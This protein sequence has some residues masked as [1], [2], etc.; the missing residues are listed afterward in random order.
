MDFI[1]RKPLIYL[2]YG[3]TNAGKNV[4]ANIIKEYY[5]NKNKKVI[6]TNFTK[7]LKIYA[8]EYLNWDGKDET[9]PRS[10]LQQ[11]GTEIIRE[12][13]DP[14]FH[15]NRTCQDI[16]IYSYL[17]DVIIIND[18]RIPEEINIIKKKYKNI[19]SIKILRPD[20]NNNLTEEQNNHYTEIALD[21]YNKW[22]YTIEN[23]TLDELKKDTIKI[24]K[25]INKDE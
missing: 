7:Y 8:Q 5:Q 4:L 12:K 1:Y 13:I 18:V 23:K 9:K 10:F 25:E 21:N 22:D 16:E 17:F 19:I 6:I 11:L 14:L 24:L 20:Y 2:I 15:I 3:K